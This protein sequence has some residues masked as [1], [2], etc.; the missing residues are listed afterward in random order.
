ML[1][2]TFLFSDLS[3]INLSSNF[4]VLYFLSKILVILFFWNSIFGE[5]FT[6]FILSSSFFKLLSFT[7]SSFVSLIFSV[8]L[9]LLSSEISF[10]LYT[11][12][13]SSSFSSL[14]LLLL[15]LLLLYMLLSEYI[16]FISLNLLKPFLKFLNLSC[17]NVILLEREWLSKEWVYFLFEFLFE[18]LFK[19]FKIDLASFSGRR[20]LLCFLVLFSN[21][22]K[23]ISPSIYFLITLLANPALVLLTNWLLLFGKIFL[24]GKLITFIKFVSFFNPSAYLICN[25]FI[26]LFKES[27]F[28]FMK[29]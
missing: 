24:F 12:S 10:K 29:L 23:F 25:S 17:S 20:I 8:V 27:I 16:E 7:F 21:S 3:E 9:L 19:F 15:L 26:L 4:I 6:W 2:N 14:I 1:I 13:K 18:F 5:F 11:I 28:S 22:F